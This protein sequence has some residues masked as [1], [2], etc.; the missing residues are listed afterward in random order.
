MDHRVILDSKDRRVWLVLK[1]PLASKVQQVVKDQLDPR[2]RLAS[3]V[4]PASRVQQV[5]K[6]QPALRDRKV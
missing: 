4:Q 2:V 6:D 5:I 3:K 1:G